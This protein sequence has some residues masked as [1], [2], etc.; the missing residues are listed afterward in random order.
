MPEGRQYRARNYER[1]GA[2]LV[3]VLELQ[4]LPTKLTDYDECDG[5][6]HHIARKT[7]LTRLLATATSRT[8]DLIELHI[9]GVRIWSQWWTGSMFSTV[10]ELPLLL[11]YAPA[12]DRRWNK[13]LTSK[14]K[15]MSLLSV[16]SPWETTLSAY[17]TD[18][19][20]VF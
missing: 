13:L 9:Y 11:W 20:Q 3:S 15:R 6:R 5:A 19:R 1:R 8:E 10:A 7:F 12:R 2:S 17:T 14:R 18:K 4:R 16:D